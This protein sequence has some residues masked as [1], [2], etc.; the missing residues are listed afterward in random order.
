M[1]YFSFFQAYTLNLFRAAI[2]FRLLGIK[3]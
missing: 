3:G 1:F 2:I